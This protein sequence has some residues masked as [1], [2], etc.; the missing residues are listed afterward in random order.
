MI[1]T[2]T[3]HTE[4]NNKNYTRVENHTNV[5]FTQDEIRL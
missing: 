4:N 2:R 1:K 5:Q 3:T